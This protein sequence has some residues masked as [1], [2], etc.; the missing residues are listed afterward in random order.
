MSL[1]SILMFPA[2]WVRYNMGWT[3]MLL[4]DVP[5]FCAATASVWRLLRQVAARALYGLASAAEVS[6]V[7]DVHRHRPVRQQHARGAR[8]AVS[9]SRANSRARRSTASNA[10]ATSGSARNITS[11]SACS[12]SSNWRSACI[13]P[14]PCSTPWSIRSTATLP[15]LMLFQIGFLYT[16]LLSILQQFTGESVMLKTPEVAK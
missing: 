15:F 6:A 16:G 7:P 3:E 1:L 9:Q 14:R 10:T 8:S 12:R 5:L 2:M 11:R 13:S 4:I